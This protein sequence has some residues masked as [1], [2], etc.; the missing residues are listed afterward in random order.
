MGRALPPRPARGDRALRIAAGRSSTHGVLDRRGPDATRSRSRDGLVDGRRGALLGA[1]YDALAPRGLHHRRRL[2]ADRRASPGSR[3]AAGSASSAPPRPH[4]RPARRRRGRARRR[5]RRRLRRAARAGPVLGAARRRRLPVRGG[6]ARSTLRT[7]PGAGHDDAAPARGRARDGAAVLE[8]WQAWSPDAPDELAAS[9][10][11]TAG[12][13]PR[14]A[15]A[16]ARLRGVARRAR[17]T[18][19]RCSA[20]SPPARPP[21]RRPHEL[22]S[23]PGRQAPA[24]R[25]RARRR[26]PGGGALLGAVRV[27]PAPAARGRR[28]RPAGPS[29]VGADAGRAARPRPLA[30]GRR[31]QPRPGARHRLPAPRRALPDQARGGRRR[32]SGRRRPRL[33][34]PLVGDRAPVRLRPR[35]PNFPDPALDDPPRPTTARTSSVCAARRRRTTPTASSGARARPRRPGSRAGRPPRGGSR[36]GPRPGG[37]GCRAARR[38]ARSTSAGTSAPSSRP[39]RPAWPRTRR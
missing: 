4:Q 17:P 21:S 26:G 34:R 27:L 31:V 33:A 38:A 5:P 36:C 19:G 28:T 6:H 14:D 37:R 10:L 12:A 20:R 32:R 15:A 16:R 35:Y 30:L 3:S 29:R 8:A 9:L 25:A 1:V 22:R 13:D 23:V 11:V 39:S 24:R 18:R 2:R 7:V